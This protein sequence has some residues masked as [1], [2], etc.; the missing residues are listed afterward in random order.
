[1][2]PKRSRRATDPTRTTEPA[3]CPAEFTLKVI[4]GK[5]KVLIVWHLIPGTRRFNEL[6]KCLPAITPRMLARQ[7]RELE[8]D[9]VLV[10]KV[11]A[12]VPPRVEYTL[13]PRGRTLNGIVKAMCDWGRRTAGY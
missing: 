7:L 6:R 4:A 12:E 8:G 10:R 11:Y 2:I 1:M 9:R 5:W 3:A 13:T